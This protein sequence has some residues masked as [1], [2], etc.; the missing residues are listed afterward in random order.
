MH[1]HESRETDLLTEARNIEFEAHRLRAEAVVDTFAGFG[2]IIAGLAAPLVRAVR[3]ISDAL[4]R[5][6]EADRIYWELSHMSNRDLADIGVSRSDIRAIAEGTFSRPEDPS[7]ELVVLRA[8]APE[9]AAETAADLDR[10]A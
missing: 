3:G 8:K 4:A 10:A 2:H 9:T 5:R 1:N 7:A 6:R